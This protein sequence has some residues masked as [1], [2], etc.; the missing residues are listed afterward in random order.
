MLYCTLTVLYT[1]NSTAPIFF[2]Y[3]LPI[4]SKGWEYSTKI[5]FPTILLNK[6]YFY[7]PPQKIFFANIFAHF[8]KFAN[9]F[10]QLR[11]YKTFS[12]TS[13]QL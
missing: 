12:Q 2:L 13:S 10:A 3:L 6:N 5:N 9:I 7:T 11:N 8:Y 4:A 1:D